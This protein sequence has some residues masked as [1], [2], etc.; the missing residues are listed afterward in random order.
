MSVRRGGFRDDAEWHRPADLPPYRC[1]AVPSRP[2]MRSSLLLVALVCSLGACSSP[3]RPGKLQTAGDPPNTSCAASNQCKVWGWCDDQGGQCV[4]TAV[5]HCKAA[6][7][8]KLGGLCTLDGGRCVAK[9]S[10]CE[11]SEWCKKNE[12]CTAEQGVCK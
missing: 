5:E 2:V 7:A 11:A 10:D 4:A 3:R 6:E 9:Q 8:C 1:L 12:L